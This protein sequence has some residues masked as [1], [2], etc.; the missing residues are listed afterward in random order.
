MH[1]RATRVCIQVT[2]V[3]DV[4][5]WDYEDVPWVGLAKVHKGKSPFIVKHDASWRRPIDDLTEYATV[6]RVHFNAGLTPEL[7]RPTQWVR[8]E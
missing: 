3:V 1:E 2:D 8:L 5:F 6:I 7:S 4:H